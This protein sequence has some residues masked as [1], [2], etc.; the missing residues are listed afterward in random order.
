MCTRFPPPSSR[1]H[2]TD[3][4]HPKRLQRVSAM[5]L[6]IF[7]VLTRSKFH[8]FE[9]VRIRDSFSV[10]NLVI[11]RSVERPVVVVL[12]VFKRSG[13]EK[14]LFF[15][16]LTTGFSDDVDHFSV[17]FSDSMSLE[18][19]WFF[20]GELLSLRGVSSFSWVTI[21][22]FGGFLFS[23]FLVSIFEAGSGFCIFSVY[24]KFKG[25]DF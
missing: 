5:V 14:V 21:S 17:F 3:Q 22:S 8:F 11:L 4:D 2:I 6:F 20:T 10:L 7:G 15:S 24:W 1:W 19:E 16:E 23:A 9:N 18:V 12:R 25:C 13:K